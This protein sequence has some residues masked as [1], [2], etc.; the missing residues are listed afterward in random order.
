MKR[1]LSIL[2]LALILIF[3]VTATANVQQIRKSITKKVGAF[4]DSKDFK[5][6]IH[7]PFNLK[8]QGY[9]FNSRT[10]STSGDA[11]VRNESL[12][13]DTFYFT[14]HIGKAF[15]KSAKGTVN[16]TLYASKGGNTG[17]VPYNPSNGSGGNPPGGGWTNGGTINAN[18]P[19]TP[20]T[21][22][23]GQRVIIERPNQ[24]VT[25]QWGDRLKGKQFK[26]RI[27]TENGHK[28]KEKTVSRMRYSIDGDKFH[29]GVY[30]W[31]VARNN[32]AGFLTDI[33][34]IGNA[35]SDWSNYTTP[36]LFRVERRDYGYNPNEPNYPW[37]WGDNPN[38]PAPN[39]PGSA[40]APTYPNYGNGNQPA[41]S[42]PNTLQ[43]PTP[44]SPAR[45]AVLAASGNINFAWSGSGSQFEV[46]VFENVAS[47]M[48]QQTVSGRS[49][50]VPA[51]RFQA[52]KT[53]KWQVRSK[54]GN[55]YS[56]YS[57]AYRFKVQNS[58]DQMRDALE[59]QYDYR[60][61][62]LAIQKL[63]SL[64][65]DEEFGGQ[66]TIMKAEALMDQSKYVD[67]IKELQKVLKDRESKDRKKA[68]YNLV[69]CYVE[70]GNKSM[71]SMYAK[72]LVEEFPG[73]SEAVEASNI[74]K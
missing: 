15:F 40:P 71:A 58:R 14:I 28:I 38:H 34:L 47:T 64:Q 13:P 63:E 46:K 73:S 23:N 48:I 39:Y 18:T 65:Q 20:T 68:L 50:S 3:A 42:N 35:F 5:E 24:N 17:Y 8:S 9:V 61:N 37:N 30:K 12:T 1:R 16:V 27:Y 62:D 66:A 67:A 10:I 31:Q 32:R 60:D 59:A 49:L 2:M 53:Y 45:D 44:N 52:G 69:N 55:M 26:I 57:P 4:H 33:P 25:F 6:A 36:T 22:S 70:L 29:S 7:M 19:P 72:K 43:T 54:S 74:I 41:P 56:P 21:P 51:S 11:S